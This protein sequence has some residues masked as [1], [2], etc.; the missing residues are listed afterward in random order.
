[1][2]SVCRHLGMS[3]QNYYAR[4]GQRQRRQIQGE[5]VADLV[6]RERQLQPRLGTRKLHHLLKGELEQAGV[7]MGR[8]RLFEELR[9]RDL[10][11]GPLPA[12][13]PHTT[14]SQHNLPVFR[15]L[16]KGK[17]VKGP[18]EV[19]VSDLSYLRTREGFVYLALVTDKFS[20]KI[21]GWHVGDNLEAAG[22][23]GALERALG[24]LPE[25]SQPIHHS[26]RGCQYCCHEYVDRLNQRGLPIS[27]TE[28]DHCAEN[29]LAERMN[30]IL[31]QEYGLGREFGTKA[32]A[33][34]AVQQG[35][36]LYNWRRPHTALGYHMPGQ[37]HRAELNL[38]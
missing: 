38:K 13:Y 31:K 26:D 2:A 1:M 21:V 12:E 34:V 3:R 7:R 11:L 6:K 9:K 17:T 27:M 8:D 30:G 33:R 4:R 19:W 15:N 16:I 23:L 22:C 32:Q 35:I 28:T 10:L 20:R 5:L 25:L 37:V 14:Q 24:E 29:A 18:N 36:E